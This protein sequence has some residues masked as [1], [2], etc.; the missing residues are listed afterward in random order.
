MRLRPLAAAAFAVA[1][2]SAQQPTAAET[3]LLLDGTSVADEL[4]GSGAAY[5]DFDGDGAVDFLV[6]A[7]FDDTAGT[8]FG[9]VWIRSGRTGA[10]LRS[11]FGVAGQRPASVGV[12]GDLDGDGFP[13][14]LIGYPGNGSAPPSPG[15]ALRAYSGLTG[16]LL[17]TFVGSAANDG[18][19]MGNAIV[20]DVDGDG[21]ADL[22]ASTVL[23]PTSSQPGYVRCYSGL[24][25]AQL[26]QR[27]GAHAGARLGYSVNAAGDVNGDGIPD[28]VAGAV[29]HNAA[30]YQ[31]GATFVFDG[32]TGATL[33]TSLANGAGDRYGYSVCGLGDLNGDGLAEVAAGTFKTS[34]G[35][36]GYA[37]VLDGATGAVLFQP[38]HA[39][40]NDH[41]GHTVGDAGDWNGDGVPDFAVSAPDANP[42]GVV[43]AGFVR[44]YSGADGAQLREFLGDVATRKFGF[45]LFAL[46][47]NGDALADL[48]VGSTSN[49]SLPGRVQIL[50]RLAADGY[51]FVSGG[52]MQLPLAWLPGPPTAPGAGQIR[53]SGATPNVPAL[54]GVSVAPAAFEIMGVDVAIDLSPG[55]WLGLP[56]VIDGVGEANL[57]LDLRTPGFAGLALY[58][59]IVALDPAG[60]QGL[61][62]T[63]GLMTLFGP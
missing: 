41:F 62:G 10:P 32:L 27:T 26:W 17:Y 47:A 40:V 12:G 48:C 28:V 16:A 20:G 19:G 5:M 43:D 35:P 63:N 8:D 55:A 53:A 46:D 39:L 29:G 49:A 57:P 60:P 15:G 33:R 21:R 42:Y 58:L 6:S 45:T 44:V 56:I 51:G 34:G 11:H 9:A 61:R 2:A 23:A 13:D 59:Q 31:A 30:G 14:Y 24:T 3:R 7:P 22:V 38:T 50:S 52:D 1:T 36:V 4:G 25:G 18:F 37:K 54:L